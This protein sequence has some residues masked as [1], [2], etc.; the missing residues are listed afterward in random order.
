[1]LEK[2]YRDNIDLEDGVLRKLH[3]S[4][5]IL[6]WAKLFSFGFA[7]YFFYQYVFQNMNSIWGITS[8]LFLGLY[9]LVMYID[10]RLQKF[11]D[12]HEN[13]K[14]TLNNELSYLDK[15]YSVF[16]DGEEFI[17]SD[18]P[19]SYDLDLFGPD[20]FF[21]RINRTVT[22]LGKEKLANSL[23]DL[24]LDTSRIQ[25]KQSAIQEL[26]KLFNWRTLF[27]SFGID[28]KYDL[29]KL[30][31]SLHGES[32]RSFFSSVAFRIA[33]LSS[34]LI[35]ISCIIAS[36]YGVISSSIAGS[37]FLLQLLVAILLSGKVSGAAYEV[38]GL[39]KGFKS[40]RELINHVM[41]GKFENQLLV[42]LKRKLEVDKN[43]DI[44]KAF[45]EL[46]S[47]L[48]RFDQRG[49]LLTFVLL[50][51]LF[52]SDLWILSDYLRWK[53]KNAI[54]MPVWV[55]VLGEF[56]MLVSLGTY[57]YNHKEN[58][59]PEL[60]DNHQAVFEARGLYHPFISKDV[61]V[62]NDFSLYKNTFAIVTGANMAGKST[63]LRAVGVNF[64]MAL[65]GLP[66]CADSFQITPM[67]LFSS[68]RT[69]DNLVKNISYFNA[70]LIRLEELIYYCKKNEHTLI[71]LDE[72]LKGTN[73]IDKLNG[74]KLLLQEISK[75]PVS[76]VIA[77][78]DLE[79][80]KLGENSD[81]FENYCFEIELSEN[82]K[83]TYKMGKGVAQ[84][85]N[86]TYLLKKIIDKIS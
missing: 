4:S 58:V 50:N 16:E 64:I 53:R 36:I 25:L 48:N 46:A 19:Y 14:T 47:I 21:N 23:L 32:K 72:I 29:E 40:Y 28:S 2:H 67:R 1:M 15:D 37:L 75:L 76:G 8:L 55:D 86:A 60:L 57:A 68:M 74:S 33:L 43:T 20:S 42:D 61:V 81:K 49:N 73:S 70:E 9:L 45:R 31:S 52:I 44:K 63:F 78:H 38:S 34:S 35:T 17:H 39:L 41:D 62:G 77:T 56:D 66:V 7:G 30:A 59:I 3:R 24:D 26:G 6:L 82:I 85:L 65:N 5:K 84:N 79:L 13:I 27:L 83:Y 18:H 12:L 10:G 71:I 22:K 80:T 54:N 11:I 51:G 69:S